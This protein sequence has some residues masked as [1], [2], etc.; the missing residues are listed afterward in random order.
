MRKYMKDN[1]TLSN[2][3]YA[4]FNIFWLDLRNK[5]L[6]SYD[7]ILFIIIK[8]IRE[9]SNIIDTTLKYGY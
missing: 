1:E 3:N 2:I 8:T 4:K 9:N 6:V 5:N 7:K